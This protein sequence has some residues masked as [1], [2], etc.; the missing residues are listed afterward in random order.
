VLT[1]DWLRPAP[2]VDGERATTELARR[3]LIGHGP[4]DDRDLARWSGLTLGRARA[5]LRA[6]A[7]EL[8]ERPDGL[9]QLTKRPRTAALPGPTLLGSF[10]PVLLGWTSREPILGAA[11]HIVTSNGM[12]RSFAMIEGTA[13]ATWTLPG[14]E[15]R[16][17]P[18]RDLTPSERG[19]LDRDGR[20]VRRFLRA[21]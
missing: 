19:A 13:A 16:L 1:A 10:D 20:D 15:V 9:V 21:T 4:A 17:D 3:F 18:L 6:I 11:T 12:F 2:A 7:T 8:K 5:G 14:G